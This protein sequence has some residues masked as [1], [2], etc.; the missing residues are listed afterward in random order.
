MPKKRNHPNVEGIENQKRS[1]DS[2]VSL[3]SLPDQLRTE[4]ISNL[5]KKSYNSKSDICEGNAEIV[6]VY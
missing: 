6:T 1:K 5:L 3:T 2:E 4:T